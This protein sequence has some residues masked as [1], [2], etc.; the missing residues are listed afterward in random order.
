MLPREQKLIHLNCIDKPRPAKSPDAIFHV[1]VLTS[2]CRRRVAH[3]MQMYEPFDIC[4]AA[5]SQFDFATHMLRKHPLRLDPLLNS[6]EFLEPLGCERL[7]VSGFLNKTQS[8]GRSQQESRLTQ[9]KALPHFHVFELILAKAFVG[10]N[11]KTL[12]TFRSE[13]KV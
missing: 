10:A 5:E 12:A 3:F 11:Q 13:P 4:D 6:K 7:C 8:V 9:R 2:F 1:Q